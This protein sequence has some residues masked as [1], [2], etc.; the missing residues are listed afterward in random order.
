MRQEKKAAAASPV[1]GSR[2]HMLLVNELDTVNR[3]P[4]GRQ[5]NDEEIDYISLSACSQELCDIR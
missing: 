4:V 1:I 5:Y 2:Y 3:T